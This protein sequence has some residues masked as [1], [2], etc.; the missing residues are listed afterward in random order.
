MLSASSPAIDASSASYPTILDITG[1]DDDPSISKDI[2]GFSRPATVTLKDLGC[3][4][5]TSGTVTNRPLY[6]SDVGP[7]YLTSATSFNCD[8]CH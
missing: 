1:I 6:L 2:Q 8:A 5:F 3:N 4:E 7:S